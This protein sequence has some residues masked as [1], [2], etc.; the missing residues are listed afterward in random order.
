MTQERLNPLPEPGVSI[1]I[2]PKGLVEAIGLTRSQ[3]QRLASALGKPPARRGNHHIFDPETAEAIIAS[4][5]AGIVRALRSQLSQVFGQKIYTTSQMEEIL[6]HHPSMLKP[7]MKQ[8]EIR[9]IKRGHSLFYTREMTAKLLTAVG[10]GQTLP[11]QLPQEISPDGAD[12]PIDTKATII[13]NGEERIFVIVA[14][15]EVD[16]KN[17]RIS[18]NSPLARAL[19]RHQEGEDAIVLA[20]RG[21]YTIRICQL[22]LPPSN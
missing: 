21:L 10:E 11:K 15:E 22:Q 13:L 4:P 14:Q 1:P 16:A 20:P 6:G 2:T 5:E 18:A 19:G 12:L 17:G 9:P 3:I 7:L 8:L